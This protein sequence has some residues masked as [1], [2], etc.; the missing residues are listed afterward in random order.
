MTYSLCAVVDLPNWLGES[1]G[2]KMK[3]KP[4]EGESCD[5]ITGVTKTTDANEESSTNDFLS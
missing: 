2:L 3:T 5:R 1:K 4:K